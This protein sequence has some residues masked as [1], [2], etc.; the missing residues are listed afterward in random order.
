MAN[1]LAVGVLEADGSVRY[2]C[3]REAPREG[4]QPGAPSLGDILGA[5]EEAFPDGQ[6]ALTGL[7]PA[8]PA[9]RDGDR[10]ARSLAMYIGAMTEE[11]T[12]IATLL[13]GSEGWAG[14]DT[15][16]TASQRRWQRWL[17]DVSE[18]ATAI[19]A[20]LRVQPSPDSA[21]TEQGMSHVRAAASRALKGQVAS[22]QGPV[23]NALKK[24]ADHGGIGARADRAD[25]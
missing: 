13:H 21:R 23:A 1:M 6:G 4:S 24:L 2:R 11:R 20:L 18:T 3:V 5:V 7:R 10:R 12:C 9:D 16:V 17:S 22:A 14:W 19:E 15:R 25:A 8:T